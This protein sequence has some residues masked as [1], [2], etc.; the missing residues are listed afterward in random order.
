MSSFTSPSLSVIIAI[1]LALAAGF[2]FGRMGRDKGDPSD[3]SRNR[4][5]RPVRPAPSESA[6][7][8]DPPTDMPPE[9]LRHLEAGKLINAIK[10]LREAYPGMGLKQ[11]KDVVEAHVRRNGLG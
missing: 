6:E 10:A 11:A 9:V 7:F 8:Q 1:L 5:P 3:F 2:L 4:L